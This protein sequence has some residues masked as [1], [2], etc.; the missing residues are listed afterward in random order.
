MGESVATNF[1]RLKPE[2]IDSVLLAN[3]SLRWCLMT[4]PQSIYRGDKIQLRVSLSNLDVL[5]AGK[6]PATIQ[7]FGPDMKPLFDKRVI[8]NISDPINGQE[9]P[10]ALTILEEAI[11]INGTAGKYKFLAT[12]EQGG[13]AI[14]GETEFYVTDSANFPELLQ[15]IVL[16]GKDSIVS[17]WLMQHKVKILPLDNSNQS[18]RQVILLCGQ[19]ADSTTMLSIARQIDCG[20]VAIFIAPSTFSS[21][22]NTTRWLPLAKKGIIAAMDN[23]GGYYRA[24]RWAK[25]HPIFNGLPSGGMMDYKYF[26][27][28]ISQNALSEQY[29][30]VAKSGYT[31]DEMDAPLINPSEVVCGATRLSHNYCSGIHIG[32]WDFGQGRFIVNT[33]HI[34]ENLGKDPAADRLF[35]NI[36]NYASRDMN[37]PMSKLSGNFNQQLVHIGYQK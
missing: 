27:N 7:V 8:V 18:K 1:R 31:Y 22:K 15:E 30:V 11:T 34:A 13:T 3:T 37:K 29:T 9:P 14:G 6:Y 4:E 19:A 23:V 24:D 10:F 36:I 32:I 28:I 5:P 2:L 16:C 35:L 25:E 12:L 21:G 20:S 33:F 17:N 26:R